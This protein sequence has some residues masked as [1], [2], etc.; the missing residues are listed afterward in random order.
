MRG[1]KRVGPSEPAAKHA[2]PKPT[3]KT[4]KPTATVENP[5]SGGGSAPAAMA[6]P[7]SSALN[8]VSGS[9]REPRKTLYCHYFSNYGKCTF[10]AR[11]GGACKF[12]HNG[13]HMCQSGMACQRNKCMFKHPNMGGMSISNPFLEQNKS[14]SQGINPWQMQM[15]NPW[16][17]PNQFQNPWNMERNRR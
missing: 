13:A 16:L 14:F 12:E 7:S 5:S 6:T 1:F 9:D 8:Q 17:N 2:N 3:P 15:M 4:K 11:T 10:E